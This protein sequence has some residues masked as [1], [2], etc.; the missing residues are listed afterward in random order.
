MQNNVEKRV[1]EGTPSARSSLERFWSAVFAAIR[2]F[3]A[4]VA[5]GALPE[6]SGRAVL[7]KNSCFHYFGSFFIIPKT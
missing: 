4:Q 6:R 7:L 1:Q 2:L 3:S 5:R